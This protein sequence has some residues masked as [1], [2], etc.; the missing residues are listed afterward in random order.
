MDVICRR[1]NR[2]WGLKCSTLFLP[3]RSPGGWLCAPTMRAA[4]RTFIEDKHFH[5]TE[6]NTTDLEL[7]AHETRDGGR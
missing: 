4:Y 7:L 3:P 2:R 5:Y 1:C 6:L